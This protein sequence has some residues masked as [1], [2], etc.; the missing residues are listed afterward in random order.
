MTLGGTTEGT[1]RT[2]YV[3]YAT[4]RIRHLHQ[5]TKLFDLNN[6]FELKSVECLLTENNMFRVKRNTF[7]FNNF[8]GLANKLALLPTYTNE[9]RE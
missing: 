1:Y 2:I 7:N 8:Q 9:I 3:R 4:L 5:A 6:F